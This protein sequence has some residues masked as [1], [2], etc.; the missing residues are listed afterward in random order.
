MGFKEKVAKVSSGTSSVSTGESGAGGASQP[1]RGPATDRLSAMK[2][3]FRAQYVNQVS[4]DCCFSGD[5][6]RFLWISV[7]VEL[8]TATGPS[9]S[10][11]HQKKEQVAV[12]TPFLFFKFIFHASGC[13]FSDHYIINTVKINRYSSF[14][15]T[16]DDR[17][18]HELISHFQR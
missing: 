13:L 2:A 3:A 4:V 7:Y 10:A 6:F 14:F 9:Y 1:S 16:D 18:L 5:Y 15:Q 11:I 12:I 17:K 8:G